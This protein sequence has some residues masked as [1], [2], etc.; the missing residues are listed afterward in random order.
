MAPSSLRHP[1]FEVGRSMEES[2]EQF[3]YTYK[4]LPF[5]L[6]KKLVSTPSDWMS[7][8]ALDEKTLDGRNYAVKVPRKP[9]V[10]EVRA[11]FEQEEIKIKRDS[12]LRDRLVIW[13]W[14]KPH[15]TRS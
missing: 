7:W 14:P 9:G 8:H 4:C 1:A 6:K 15:A 10:Y 5:P 3:T 12:L 2:M 13:R 11:T